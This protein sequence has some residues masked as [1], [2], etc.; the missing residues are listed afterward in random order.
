MN[1][2]EEML[3]RSLGGI[4]KVQAMDLA[5]RY[6]AKYDTDLAARITERT[7]GNYCKALITWITVQDPTG[8]LEDAISHGQGHLTAQ[9]IANVKVGYA[10][11]C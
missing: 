3:S 8:G 4:S 11:F 1:C 2:D 9:A 7:G 10:L 5:A 6:R